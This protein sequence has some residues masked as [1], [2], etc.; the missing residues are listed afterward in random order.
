MQLRCQFLSETGRL[1]LEST[2]RGK[3][4]YFS[5]PFCSWSSLLNEALIASKEQFP[6]IVLFLSFSVEG[7]TMKKALTLAAIIAATATLVACGGG[8]TPAPAASAADMAAS[9]AEMSASAAV[10]ATEEAASA[11]TDAASEA[12][13]AATDAASDAAAAATEAAS[14]AAA[15][16]TDAVAEAVDAAKAAA[17]AAH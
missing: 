13:A 11:A 4:K 7:S 2:A 5:S 16:A 8:N 6:E 10:T 15:A 14:H 17:S 1:P 3:K 9:A 12:A